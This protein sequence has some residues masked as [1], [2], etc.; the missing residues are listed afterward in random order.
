MERQSLTH[1]ADAALVG[2]SFLQDALDDISRKGRFRK[3]EVYDPNRIDFFSNDYLG[4]ARSDELY[5]FFLDRLKTKK[6]EKCSH[7]LGSTGSRLI[8]GNSLLCERLEKELADFHR[9]EAGLIFNSGY[10]ANLGI[11]SSIPAKGDTIIYDDLSHASIREGVRLSFAKSYSFRHND[12]NDLERKLSLVKKGGR[13]YIAVE[14][15]YSMDGDYAPLKEIVELSKRY[16]AYPIV[17]EAHSNGTT[18]S[19]GEGMV[20]HLGLTD[21][22][23]AR[24]HTFGKGM[25]CHGSIVLGSRLLKKF[26]VNK[27][28]PFIYTTALPTHSLIA[29]QCAYE[30]LSSHPELITQLNRNI[31]IFKSLIPSEIQKKILPGDSAIQSCLIENDVK[32]KEVARYLQEN[33]INVK[34]IVS[35]TVPRGKERI[36]ICLHTFNS[37]DEIQK[38]ITALSGA[39]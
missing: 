4:L 29:I 24:L 5:K 30:Y 20:A 26:L 32:S 9:A 17:D 31:S 23:L 33:G 3:L 12:M 15:L 13:T 28:K 6:T 10:D 27:A 35:P 7:S 39:V 38:L 36:R 25:G 8:S 22:F 34:A 11:F 19:K 16:G 2:E 18:G 1:S 37:E 14:A 21:S